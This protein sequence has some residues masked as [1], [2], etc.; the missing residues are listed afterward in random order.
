[1]AHT[2]QTSGAKTIKKNTNRTQ[3]KS[4]TPRAKQ[5]GVT[6]FL[7]TDCEFS[8]DTCSK[9]VYS[10]GPW[11]AF[12]HWQEL[13]MSSYKCHLTFSGKEKSTALPIFHCYTGCD[14]T[15]AFCG[16]GKKSAWEAWTSYPEVTRAFNYMTANRHSP[17]TIGGHTSTFWSA[18]QSSSTTRRA[19]RVL[20][21]KHGESC[22]AI[23]TKRW[24]R[25]HQLKMPCCRSQNELPTRLEYGRHVNWP[26]SRHPVQKDVDGDSQVWRPVWSTLSMASK[27]CLQLCKCGCCRSVSGCG[28]RSLCKKTHSKCTEPGSCKCDR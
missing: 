4:Q 14:T 5:Y 24:N 19:I 15:S 2:L 18:T 17:L 3:N 10:F 6:S 26:I 20:S 27:A 25:S 23:R 8:T 9:N 11:I 21:M 28:G 22:S 1:M 7:S 16:K 12:W 13:H